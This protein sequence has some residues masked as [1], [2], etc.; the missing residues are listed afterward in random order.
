[1][2]GDWFYASSP[3]ITDQAAVAAIIRIASSNFSLTRLFLAQ[4]ERLLALNPL[5]TVTAAV[6]EVSRKG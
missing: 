4:A 5:L 6:V 3:G 1:L 2:V